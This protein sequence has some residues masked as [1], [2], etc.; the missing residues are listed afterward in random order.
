MMPFCELFQFVSLT[1]LEDFFL[2][3]GL[4]LDCVHDLEM[5]CEENS[6]NP[7]SLKIYP[8]LFLYSKIHG[9]TE[10]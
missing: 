8:L 5:F 7:I 6:H 4:C 10:G 1:P 9:T 3:T 2:K